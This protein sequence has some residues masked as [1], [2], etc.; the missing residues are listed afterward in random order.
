MKSM[1]ETFAEKYAEDYDPEDVFCLCLDDVPGGVELP[2]L[3]SV[4]AMKGHEERH[5]FPD[6]SALVWGEHA[7]WTFGI[8]RSL[9][10]NERVRAAFESA[11]EDL[12]LTDNGITIDLSFVMN[13]D[14]AH[15]QYADLLEDMQLVRG[16]LR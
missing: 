16:T 1:A 3:V 4:P 8:H 7:G 14:C 11:D 5:E 15:E 2:K 10:D 13:L 6:G 12:D 9:L